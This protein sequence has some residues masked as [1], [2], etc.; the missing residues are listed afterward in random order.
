MQNKE[1]TGGLPLPVTTPQTWV[2]RSYQSGILLIILFAL[3]T[4]LLGISAQLREASLLVGV[5][6]VILV[7]TG[8]VLE[9]SQVI[10]ILWEKTWVKWLVGVSAAFVWSLSSL[11][12]RHQIN[13][14]THLF[15]EYF[16]ASTNWLAVIATPFV[17]SAGLYLMSWALIPLAAKKSGGFIHKAGRFL[18]ALSAIFAMAAVTITY[19]AYS[20][21]IVRI[22]K[23]IIANVDHYSASHCSNIRAPER[24]AK[25]EDGYVSVATYRNNDWLFEERECLR[26]K[27]G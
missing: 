23:S 12:A 17:L 11:L 22:Q 14:I 13:A 1:T 7:M 20:D 26:M 21:E 5:A 27:E 8:F 10:R 3:L 15:P 16:V 18:G 4:I 25:T 24:V 9:G 2:A 19:S 6:G